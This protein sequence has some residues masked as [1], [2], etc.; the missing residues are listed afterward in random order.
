MDYILESEQKTA[1]LARK[2][3]DNIKKNDIITFDGDLGC[4]K[5]FFC[6]EIINHLCGN[7]VIVASPT[8]NI[9]QVYEAKDFKIFH[10][11]LY[12]IKS[13][14]ELFELNIEEALENVMLVE[15]PTKITKFIEQ[16]PRTSISL[17]HQSNNSRLC[18]I[19]KNPKL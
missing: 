17:V 1:E 3:A 10:Y 19:E 12:R 15:W 13:V 5:T 16:Y 2:V 6:R 14:N 8:F 7:D 11:D 18:K 4:G 9:L